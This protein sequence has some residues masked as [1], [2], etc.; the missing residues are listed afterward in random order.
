MVLGKR[1]DLGALQDKKIK[2]IVEAE[3]QVKKYGLRAFFETYDLDYEELTLVR[4][5]ILPSGKSRAFINDT[6]VTLDIVSQL[7]NRLIDVHSQHQT[8]QLGNNDFQMKVIDA[9][10]ENTE[11]LSNYADNLKQYKKL[12]RE[13]EELL[14]FQSNAHKEHDY[15]SF[16]LK[17]LEATTLKVGLQEEL[18]QQYEQ[19]NNMERIIELLAK[20]NQLLIDEQVG[21]LTSLSELKQVSARLSAFG[22]SY[23]ALHQR[24]AS[25]FIEM[26]DISTELQALVEQAE[27][28]PQMLDEI[29]QKL[30][31]LFDLH[32]K[33]GTSEIAELIALR[34]DLS[35]KVGV[36]ENLETT[37]GQKQEQLEQAEHK[38][39]QLATV[40]HDRRKKVIPQLKEQLETNLTS[41]GMPNATFDITIAASNDFKENGNDDLAFLFSANKGADFGELKKVASG[42]ELSRIMLTIKS[43]LAKYEQLPTM[44]FDEIDTGVSGEISNSIADIMQQMGKSMQVFSI[45]HLPQ[46]ASKG[47][48]HFKVYKVDENDVTRTRMKPLSDDERVV[49]LAE[50]LGGKNLSDSALAHARQLLN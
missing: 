34:E 41:L 36:T 24:I 9:L 25:S 35:E 29:S 26:D 47:K 39:Q 4:R 7:G 46:V 2:C 14:A 45:T 5:E 50:M 20:G 48:Q 12:A 32:K 40:L 28:N 31:V 13:L 22:T 8:L 1:A 10:A 23:D 15:N 49:E 11:V 38:L 33:H 16:L 43:I 19:L 44:M 27:T 6:P 42:G 18:E 30:Q 17:E 21:V 3:F 37:I